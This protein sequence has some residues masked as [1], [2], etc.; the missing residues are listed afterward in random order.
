[1]TPAEV[2]EFEREAVD[3]P[4]HAR[5]RAIGERFGI[6]LT[7]YGQ[8][9]VHVI[10]DPMSLW[11]AP[12]IVPRLRRLRDARRSARTAHRLGSAPPA[13]LPE[14]RQSPLPFPTSARPHAKED[15]VEQLSMDA[16]DRAERHLEEA[17]AAIGEAKKEA[18][19][20]LAAGAADPDWRRA[21]DDAIV[22][23]AST[24]DDAG[25]LVRFTAEDIRRIAGDPPDHPNAMG[26]RFY[27]AARRGVIRRV[28][29]RK[30]KRASL[31]AHPIAVWQ[32]PDR[33]EQGEEEVA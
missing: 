25:E 1:M 23:L 24:R 3:W 26:A 4:R 28:A 6:S 32:G 30:S 9:L 19:M 22:R 11:A 29:Y 14:R 5:E 21:V 17:S 10:Q 18:G 20:Q 16:I 27:I 7:R 33:K 31:H 8:R 2:L 13:P 15:H 12:D